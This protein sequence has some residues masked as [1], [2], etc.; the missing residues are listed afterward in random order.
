MKNYKGLNRSKGFTLMEL[1]IVII[2]LGIVLVIVA[3]QFVGNT[4]GAR[5]KM[6]Q[7][8]A[9]AT[10]QN[11]NILSQTCG[12]ST[13]ISGN[14][15]PAAGKTMAD[16]IYGGVNNVSATYRT[17]YEQSSIRS[18]RDGVSSNGSGWQVETYPITLGGGGTSKLTVAFATVPDEV[19][20]DLARRYNS[21]LTALAAS[22]TTGDVIRYTGATNGTRTVTVLLD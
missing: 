18:L 4:T 5:A 1:L 15:I 8:M 13:A 6:L 19:T 16:V 21:T 10:V 17:C 22:D 7:R 20:L 11:I 2:V 12:T 3:S 14:P 9:T